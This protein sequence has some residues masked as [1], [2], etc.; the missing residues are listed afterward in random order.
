MLVHQRV[1]LSTIHR[2]AG[3]PQ[4]PVSCQKRLRE[5]LREARLETILGGFERKKPIENDHL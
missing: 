4:T 3:F 2:G 5:R 1:G